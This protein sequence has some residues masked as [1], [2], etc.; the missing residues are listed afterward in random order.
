MCVT[1]SFAKEK[2]NIYRVFVFLKSRIS[3]QNDHIYSHSFYFTMVR[4][5]V[6]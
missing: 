2:S 4:V 3:I 6:L 5:H 1:V